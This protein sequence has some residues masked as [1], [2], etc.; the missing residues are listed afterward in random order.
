MRHSTSSTLWPLL[1]LLLTLLPSPASAQDEPSTRRAANP[2]GELDRACSDCH[3]SEAWFPLAEPPVFDHGNDTGFPLMASH[4]GVQC[5]DC[6]GDLRFS[7]VATACADC[8]RD[9]HLGE[10][11]LNCSSCH[12]SRG[13]QEAQRRMREL[14][15]ASLFPLTG[16]HATADCASCHGGGLTG[17]AF[18]SSPPH[19]FSVTPTDCFSC[20]SADYQRARDPVHASAGFPTTCET[21]HSTDA[22]R[23]ADF[24]AHDD[25][26]FPI[27]SGEHDG[28]WSACS[29]CHVAPA[30]FEVF[31]CFRC[32]SRGEMEDEHDDVNGYRYDS[33]AC[34]SCHPDGRE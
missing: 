15:A 26:F 8:H 23:P 14:H 21:C 30:T 16:A 11:G 13:W 10:L 5:L 9:P 3:T 4:R 1:A 22:W 20:H 18:T 17:G 7:F 24:R 34:Y 33:M 12:D 28:V 25:V 6:H 32:H 19:E 29:D 31:S 2:H 27:F